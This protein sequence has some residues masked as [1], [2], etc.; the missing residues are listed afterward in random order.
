MLI[1]TIYTTIIQP[2]ISVNKAIDVDFTY[3]INSSSPPLVVTFEASSI[4]AENYN[5]FVPNEYIWTFYEFTNGIP[6]DTIVDTVVK[7]SNGVLDN[8]IVK[9]F[10]NW[11]KQYSVKLQVNYITN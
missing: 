2:A 8:K 10:P 7:D 9:T 1:P 3:V 11:N 4:P 5:N 6:S